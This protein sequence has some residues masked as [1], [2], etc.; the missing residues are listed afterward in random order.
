MAGRIVIL[1]ATGGIGAAL[2]RR[3]AARGATPVLMARDAARLEALAAEIPGAEAHVVDVTDTAA[4]KS[5]ITGLGGPLAGLAYCVGSILL[6]PATRVTE[7]DLADTY[8]LNVIGAAMAVQAAIPALQ[9]GNGSVVLFSSVAARAGFANHLAIGAAK[10]AVEGMTV[11]LAAELAPAVRV[12]CIAPSLTRTRIAEPLTRNPAMAEAIGK[13]HPIPRLGEPE[14]VAALADLLLSP[15]AGWIT[16]QVIG[17]D[18]GRGTLR[19]KTG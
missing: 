1:G 5:A 13:L 12:N 2:A 8:R 16:G 18:G 9:A 6:K 4:L 14:D 7:A 3:V 17:V 19:T 15:D 10:A 11:S